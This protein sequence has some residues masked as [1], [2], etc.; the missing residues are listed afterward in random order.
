MNKISIYLDHAAST[1][2]RAEALEDMMP[3]LTDL[4]G[5]PSSLYRLGRESKKAI[6]NARESAAA[7]IGAEVNELYFTGG[8]TEADNWAIR[9]VAY[10]HRHKGNH[11]ITSSIEHPAVRNTC[12]QLEREGFRVT[13]LPVDGEGMVR[14]EGLSEAIEADTILI[15]IM[16]ANNEVGVIQQISEIGTIAKDRN[17]LFHTD[18]VQ[19]VG[20]I[21]VNVQESNV[22]LLSLSAHKFYGPKGVGALYVKNGVKL[23]NLM[24]GGAQEKRQRPGTENVANV[25][26]LAKALELAVRDLPINSNHVLKLRDRT[27]DTILKEIPA[28][29]LNGHRT[30]RLPGNANFSFDFVDGESLLILLDSHGISASSGSACASGSLDPSPTLIAMGLDH[31]TAHSS[32]RFSFGYENTEEEVDVL[33]RILP[34][35]VSKLRN[36]SPLYRALHMGGGGSDE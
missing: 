3:Y 25:V 36:L 17:I 20:S 27:I 35:A 26:G 9:G 29:K 18:A 1:P 8:G 2:L 11:I 30:N 16:Y 28:S 5:N 6:G 24:Q 13:Y 23:A 21:P 31:E 22:D 7:S 10:G 33:L 34:D 14:L 15:T 4:Y 32:L 12:K 19:A